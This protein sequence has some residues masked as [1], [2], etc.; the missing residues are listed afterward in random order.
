MDGAMKFVKG[1]A[2]AAIIITLVN[3]VGGLIIG[4]AMRGLSD[5]LAAQQALL[6][7]QVAVAQA[8]MLMNTKGQ[9]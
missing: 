7:M 1:D 2:I 8:S 9:K 5:Q 4:V 3:I 6:K